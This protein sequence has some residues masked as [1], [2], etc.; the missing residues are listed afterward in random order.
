MTATVPTRLLALLG[1]V[2]AALAVFT[3]AV[4]PMLLDSD[5][6]AAPSVTPSPESSTTKPAVPATSPAVKPAKPAVVLNPGLPANLARALRRETVVVAAVYAPGA[7]DQAAV[8]QART[9][10]REVGA[11]FVTLNVLREQQARALESLVGPISDPSVLVFKRP[12]TVALRLDGFA[13]SAIVAQAAQNA[14]AR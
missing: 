9:G 3:F 1:L 7:G 10:A 8:A 5:E 12:G 14:G 13:D 11:G 4:R 6:T 2:A